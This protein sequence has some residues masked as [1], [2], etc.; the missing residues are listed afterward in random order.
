MKLPPGSPGLRFWHCCQRNFRTFFHLNYH[1]KQH[2]MKSPV[3]H[4]LDFI[5]E[6]VI[7]TCFTQYAVHKPMISVSMLFHSLHRVRYRFSTKV[8]LLLKQG[9]N[10]PFLPL[11]GIQG[12]GTYHPHRFL[13]NSILFD[14]M[15]AFIF[16]LIN[17]IFGFDE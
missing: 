15:S 5:T 8:F 4:A 1:A 3:Q 17:S 16:I 12:I 7:L 13:E 9:T 11:P 10:A 2:H 6:F 14:L